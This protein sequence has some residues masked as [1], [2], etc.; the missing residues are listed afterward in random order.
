MMA[1]NEIE[2]N[3]PLTILNVL[4]TFKLEKFVFLN[5]VDNP[6]NLK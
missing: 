5:M 3:Y 4:I 1:E 2:I 6:D